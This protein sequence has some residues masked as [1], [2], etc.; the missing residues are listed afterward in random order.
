MNVNI[1]Y[2]S[3]GDVAGQQLCRMIG[4][5]KQDFDFCPYFI[6]TQRTDCAA[7]PC[8]DIQNWRGAATDWTLYRHLSLFLCVCLQGSGRYKERVSLSAEGGFWRVRAGRGKE[9]R[10]KKHTRETE[11]E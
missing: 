5:K 3:G 6:L 9:E 7:L 4:L 1:I 10:D 8:T 2:L 11:S